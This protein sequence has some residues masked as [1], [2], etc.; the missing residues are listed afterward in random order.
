[1]NSEAIESLKKFIDSRP[2]SRELTR[3]LAV[4]LTF[5]GYAYRAI[6]EILQVSN[7]FITKWKKSFE[8]EGIEGIKLG[9]QGRKR[10]L[11]PQ[12]REKIINWIIAQKSWSTSEVERELME[13]Y[14]V[15]FKSLQSY[16]ELLH[17]A[18]KSWQKSQ[19]I[20]P[21]QDPEQVKKKPRNCTVTRKGKTRDRS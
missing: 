20:H 3:A 7:A 14:D 13:R 18:Q 19:K 12:Q 9:Y 2:D 11:E 1:M 4:K 16:Y 17:E 21:R 10:Y 5:E 6:T 15:V 8:E